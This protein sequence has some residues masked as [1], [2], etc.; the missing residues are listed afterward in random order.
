MFL[1][2]RG[3]DPELRVHL[4]VSG[5]LTR[6]RSCMIPVGLVLVTPYKYHALRQADFQRV[7]CGTHARYSIAAAN[8]QEQKRVIVIKRKFRCL[9]TNSI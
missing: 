2:S 7:A 3:K 4:S 9:R 6:F 8:E 1:P 5:K